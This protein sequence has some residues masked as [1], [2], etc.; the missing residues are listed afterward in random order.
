MTWSRLVEETSGC[1][2][3]H[4]TKQH[5]LWDASQVGNLFGR[6][7]P[8]ERDTCQYLKLTQPFQ[9]GKELALCTLREY[10]SLVFLPLQHTW[11]ARC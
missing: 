1:R 2:H 9:T 10:A 3:A 7:A 11:L 6:Y 5:Q 4:H 8:S